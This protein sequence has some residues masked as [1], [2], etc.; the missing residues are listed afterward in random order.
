MNVERTERPAVVVQDGMVLY[1]SDDKK[2]MVTQL[3]LEDGRTT[4]P[5]RTVGP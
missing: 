2:V 5:S 4:D 3:Q 1:G